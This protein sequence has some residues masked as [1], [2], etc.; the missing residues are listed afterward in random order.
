MAKSNAT[1]MEHEDGN[2]SFSTSGANH[3][4]QLKLPENN[5]PV[6]EISEEEFQQKKEKQ[7][8]ARVEE[9]K[10]LDKKYLQ[11]KKAQNKLVKKAHADLFEKAGFSLQ[12]TFDLLGVIN[13]D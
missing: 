7:Y 11:K 10:E 13:Q 2:F 1:Y 9:Q 4:A 6:K 5:R 8:E 12:D 3:V